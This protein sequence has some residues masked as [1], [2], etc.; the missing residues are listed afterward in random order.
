MELCKQINFI[1]AFLML[2]SHGWQKPKTVCFHN[3]ALLKRL[4]YNPQRHLYGFVAGV[5]LC[6]L[7]SYLLQVDLFVTL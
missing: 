3:L 4:S 7:L 5:N 6:L 2:G 1:H